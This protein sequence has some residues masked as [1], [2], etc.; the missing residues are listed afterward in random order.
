[1]LPDK[2]AKAFGE[3]YESARYNKTLDPKTTLMIHMAAAM[4]AAC[5]P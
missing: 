1:V 2:Q 3:F 4:S 5:Y